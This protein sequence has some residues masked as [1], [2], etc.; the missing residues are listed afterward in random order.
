[1]EFKNVSPME[2][3]TGLITL[4]AKVFVL[5]GPF[6]LACCSA[7]GLIKG[8]IALYG[9][10]NDNPAVF[11]MGGWKIPGII[12]VAGSFYPLS[13]YVLLLINNMFERLFK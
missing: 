1:M 10:M 9:I 6:V 7:V 11:D 12:L 13:A 2:E 5:L 8:G 4:S 3:A